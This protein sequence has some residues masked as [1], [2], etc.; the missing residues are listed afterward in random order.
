MSELMALRRDAARYRWLRE[1]G[2]SVMGDEAEVEMPGTGEKRM[3]PV[4]RSMEML[5]QEIDRQMAGDDD[6]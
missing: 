2:A 4:W 6:A 5:D 3:T 1:N